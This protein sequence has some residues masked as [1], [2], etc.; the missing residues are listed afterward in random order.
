MSNHFFAMMARMKYIERWALMRNSSSE[1]LSEHSLD[2]AMIAHALAVIGNLRL[3]KKLDEN[4]AAIVA[5]YH[6][7]TEIITG[8]LPTPVKYFNADIKSAYKEVEHVA[9]DRLLSLLPEDM[10]DYYRDFYYKNDEDAYIWKLVKAADKLS[11]YIKCIEEEKAGNTEFTNAKESTMKSLDEMNI[12]EVN[13]FK[14]EFLDSYKL[15][16]DELQ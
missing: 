11:A 6:D 10:Q 1:N 7:T 3:G 5:L 13:I 8:D 14:K 9:A 15:T 4:K 12:E 16:L 2:V